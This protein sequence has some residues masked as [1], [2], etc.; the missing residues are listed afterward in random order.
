[1]RSS[2]A[3]IVAFASS[4][5][6]PFRK[7]ELIAMP[8]TVKTPSVSTTPSARGRTTCRLGR[9]N[10]AANAASRASCAGTAMMAPVP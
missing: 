1:L 8:S 2:Q 9:A 10:F 3:V 5:E 6:R 7:S 4:V